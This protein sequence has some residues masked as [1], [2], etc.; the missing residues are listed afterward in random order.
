MA[1]A[2]CHD[3]RV[4]SPTGRGALL[5]LG[6]SSGAGKTTIV[7]GLCRSLARRGVSVAPF[8]AQNMS[9]NSFVTR[10]G[11]ELARAQAAQALAAGV[12][13]EAAMN[14]V[15]LKPGSDRTSHVM[16]MGKPMGTLEARDWHG[17]AALLDVVVDAYRHLRARFDVVLCEGAGS[18]AET[19]LRGSD[20]V[21]LGFARAVGVPA[22][23]VGDIDRGGVF[24]SFVGTLAVLDE[25]DRALIRGFVVNRFRGDAH[26]LTP[27]LEDLVRRTGRPVYGVLPHVQGLGIDTEDMPDPSFYG[28]PR[29][30][31]GE[32]VLRVGMVH[33]P[34][35]SN[36]TDLDPLVVEPGV[37]VRFVHHP[38]E[39][40][41]C[42]LVVLP[43]TRAT[44]DALQWLQ[45][46]GFDRALA[47]RAREQQPILGICGGYQL[48][49]STIHDEVETTAGTVPAL[50]LLPVSTRFEHEKTLG[51]P[52]A[53]LADGELV[54]G[55][56]IHHGRVTVHGGEAFF[57]QE[58][59]RQ[60]AV[61]GTTW[62]GLFENDSLRHAYLR[63]V[64]EATGR[65]F[66][67]DAAFSFAAWRAERIDLVAD[68][69][70]THLDVSEMLELL[71]TSCP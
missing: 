31:S 48:L 12:E 69:V 49:G 18:P 2:A 54:E 68:L 15:L 9:L 65:R 55:Y 61:A 5:V 62:H 20:I 56:E 19:N 44:V 11:E 60:G 42:D 39:M 28:N 26:L 40:A 22:V 21:N 27:A 51:R 36:L 35:A 24:A 13:P 52:S 30:P 66:V 4:T 67:P 16:V 29:P 70:D 8:K 46:R 53:R 6:T 47:E 45:G 14:P 33:L 32:D 1:Q 7:M 17:K 23:V 43:G 71:A 57:A 64:A 10:R 37:V 41:D 38:H 50:G 25:D 59:C 58:G 34:R 3:A 63:S